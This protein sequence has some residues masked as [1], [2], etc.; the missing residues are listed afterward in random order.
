MVNWEMP[1]VDP[2]VHHQLLTRGGC[3]M[4]YWVVIQ[5]RISHSWRCTSLACLVTVYLNRFLIFMAKPNP[6]IKR[7]I[8]TNSGQYQLV[9]SAIV[10]RETTGIDI[11]MC[12]TGEFVLWVVLLMIE[13]FPCRCSSGKTPLLLNGCVSI[14]SPILISRNR[15]CHPSWGAANYWIRGWFMVDMIM[16]WL[17]I[18]ATTELKNCVGGDTPSRRL[19]GS[20]DPSR[21]I[22]RLRCH[23]SE[24]CRIVARQSLIVIVI[25][26]I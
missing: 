10:L 16:I 25:N 9:I 2:A 24:S 20:W 12:T 13:V 6:N 11:L 1:M 15:S 21:E 23:H 3:G 26:H 4:K 5:I 7:L 22:F 8:T 14:M 17:G 18:T 19:D